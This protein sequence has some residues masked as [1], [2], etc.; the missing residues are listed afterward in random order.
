MTD[1]INQLQYCVCATVYVKNQENLFL[2]VFHKKLRKWV[3]PGGKLQQ[4][5]LPHQAA[6]REC[7]EQTGV[8]IRILSDKARLK[9]KSSCRK[10][11]NLMKKRIR[12]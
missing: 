8:K 11:L 5:E 7:Y 4:Q 10:A 12:A 1:N 3:P 2:M 6:I 9:H